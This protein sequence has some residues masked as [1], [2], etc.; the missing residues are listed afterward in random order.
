MHR[1]RS[2]PFDSFTVECLLISS[3]NLELTVGN[4]NSDSTP[5]SV[6]KDSKFECLFFNFNNIPID[7]LLNNVWV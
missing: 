3:K 4:R 7:F 6:A 1:I 5:A 2:S